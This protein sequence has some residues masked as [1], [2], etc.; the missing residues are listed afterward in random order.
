MFIRRYKDS[1]R[2]VWDEF[3]KLAKVNHFF[4]LR[5]FMEYH[6]DRFEDYSLLIFDGN[7]KLFA[8]LPANISNGTLYSHQG[9]TFGGLVIKSSAKQKEVIDAFNTIKLFLKE[10][11]FVSLLYKK[12]PYIYNSQPF[13]EDLYSLFRIGA[14]LVRR[15]VSST[16]KINNQ[17]KYSKGRKWVVKKANSS[18]VAYGESHDLTEFWSNLSEVLMTGHQAKPVHTFDEIVSLV[19]LFPEQIK[20]YSACFNGV[21]VAGAVVFI[22]DAVAHTQYLYNTEVGR[23]IGALDGLVDYLVKTVFVDKEYFDFGTSNEDQGRHLNEGLIS[24][25]EGFG[26][27]A[28]VHDFY[29]IKSND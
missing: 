4:F 12:V 3:V 22:T 5:D 2:V 9:L 25:K 19:S 8:V 29:E 16:I 11:G 6:A 23:S 26:A 18:G 17:I 10:N 15:D 28:V 24:Q 1:D 14:H 13:D 20:I 27:R 21:Q 7:D